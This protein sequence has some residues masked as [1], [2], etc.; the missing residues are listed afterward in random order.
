[1]ADQLSGTSSSAPKETVSQRPKNSELKSSVPM[2]NENTIPPATKVLVAQSISGDTPRSS[3]EFYAMSNNSNETLAS[4]YPSQPRLGWGSS[5]RPPH[6]RKHSNL[7]PLGQHSSSQRLES[8][9]MAY[10]QVQ[11]SFTLDGSL[12]NLGP[13]DQVKRK[14]VV[15][16][17][18]G[19]VV[20]VESTRQNGGLLRGF[21][22][23]NLLDDLVGGGELSTIKEMRGVA[24][25]KSIPLL[26]TPQSILFVDAKL[27]PGDSKAFDYS[28]R[29]PRGLPPSHKGKAIKIMYT[30]V[31]GT[32]R[33]GGSR[34]QQ[35][36]TV[37]VPFRVLGSV[38]SHGEILGHD[39]MSPYVLLSDKA[40]VQAVGERSFTRKTHGNSATVSSAPNEFFMY[41]DE[42]L[43][44]SKDTP[45]VGLLSPTDVTPG[46]RR[47]SAFEEAITTKEAIDMAILR[48]NIT[49][50][51]Q[52]AN[53]FEIARN[54]LRVGMVMLVRPTYRL[55]EVV[56]MVVD[57]SQAQVPCYAVHATLETAEKID[58]SLA[59][60][61][62]ASVH[63]VT[64]KVYMSSSETTLYSRRMVFTPTI[65]ITATPEF[66]TSGVSFEW[67]LRLEFVVPAHESLQ[68]QMASA[69]QGQQLPKSG[70]AG[71]MQDVY[72]S[73]SSMH[74][75]T[76]TPAHHL[77]EE[78]SNDDR[79]G[80]ILAAAENLICESFE[81]VVP[82]RVYGTVAT[83]LEKL[84]RDEALEEGLVI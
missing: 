22:L 48:S 46:F 80:L 84:E 81:V 17:Q 44:Q 24:N 9:M 63:R 53:R 55:G 52:S 23:G 40:V 30:L 45:G 58:H 75:A 79:G 50:G 21:G 35:V 83:G 29:L 68:H 62:E 39:L 18:G 67:K 13:F 34:E 42:L 15:G 57:F 11:G 38:N 4:E 37:E 70:P 26:S 78:I 14:A 2:I 71:D 25:A 73:E 28:F 43:N 36:R 16:G 3:G 76:G 60:R 74:T 7:S 27:G 6:M 59:L 72:D 82:L 51:Q 5:A 1:M 41:V 65:P 61:S 31:V 49:D 54:G 77:L 56:I 32:Q 20:G 12:I 47:S 10:A 33:A 8:I 69:G 64:R 19:G 66:V